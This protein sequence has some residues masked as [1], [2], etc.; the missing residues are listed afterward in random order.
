MIFVY[1]HCRLVSFFVASINIRV[2]ELFMY[3]LKCQNEEHLDSRN[4]V[5]IMLFEA[6][7]GEWF[8]WIC[9]AIYYH[10]G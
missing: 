6:T 10:R 4:V 8:K 3:S 2:V 9:E 1:A 5:K 7:D